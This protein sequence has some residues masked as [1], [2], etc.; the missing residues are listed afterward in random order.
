MMLNE[1][2][3]KKPHTIRIFWV[4]GLFA[5]FYL[6][7][8]LR[9]YQ[10]QILGNAKLD[11]LASVQHKTKLVI[12]PRRGAIYDRNGEVLAMDVMVASIGLHPHLVQE[13]SKVTAVL[14]KHTDLNAK[15]LEKKLSSDK[16][17]IWIQRRIPLEKGQAIA[18]AKLKGVQVL[19]EF[20]RYYP[21]KSLAGQLLGAVGYDAKALGGLEMAYDK[22]LKAEFLKTQA[23]RDARGKLFTLREEESKNHDLYLTIDKNIQHFTEIALKENAEKHKVKN[24][25]AIV[26]N[27]KTGEILALANYPQFNPNRYWSYPQKFWK[28]HAIIDTYEPGS[29]FKA[30]LLAS[31]LDTGKIRV[32]DRI[33]CENGT[34]QI[35]RNRIRDHG[36][37]YG[38]I[39]VKKIF[40]VSSNIGLTKIGFQ[41]GKKDFYNFLKKSGFGER[42][43]IGLLGEGKGFLRNYKTW[44]DIEFSNITFGQ[45]LTVTGLQM[46]SV[47]AGLA[48]HGKQM[49]PFLLK[50]I[51]SS[52]DEV[53]VK[54]EPRLKAEIIKEKTSRDLRDLFFSVTQEGGTAPQAHLDGYLAGGKTGTAQKVDPKTKR[55]SMDLYVSSFIGFAPLDDPEL[56]IYVVY[57]SPRKNGYYGGSV[58]GPVFKKIAEKSL[59]YMGIAP[60][61]PL[62]VKYAKAEQKHD[63]K[64]RENDLDQI[65]KTLQTKKM[66]SL[67]GLSM[68][69]VLKLANEFDV[70]VKIKGSGFVVKQFPEKNKKFKKTW[71]LILTGASS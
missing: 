2:K 53:I 36:K 28:N 70:E 55:Y 67:K 40:Q 47:Y 20:R 4:G 46:T 45:G 32:T 60:T 18:E 56:V 48:N 27:A 43:D 37:G 57:D 44:K 31:A 16:R 71:N 11:H 25:F 14:E 41:T 58:A 49:Q 62:S 29:T 34:L 13:K 6:V 22:Y 17:F 50:K 61:H 19:H 23:T 5:L 65:R 38:L 21:N 10:L 66:P 52:E 59:A 33:D 42:V 3:T 64:K 12:Q 69:S 24:G 30:M 54:N 63:T 39:D 15:D 7:I 68:R 26:L 1:K 9:S 51:I 8:L 35:G